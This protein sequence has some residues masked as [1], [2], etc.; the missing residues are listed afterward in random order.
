[1]A[2]TSASVISRRSFTSM[3]LISPCTW[4][5]MDSFGLSFARIAFL[6]SSC[7]SS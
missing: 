2:S 6:I 1:M 4:R 3:F 7:S 5:R